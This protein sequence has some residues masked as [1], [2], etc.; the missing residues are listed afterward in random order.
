MDRLWFKHTEWL[1][2]AVA[3]LFFLGAYLYFDIPMVFSLF[4][5]L[6][7]FFCLFWIARSLMNREI[8]WEAG[9]MGPVEVSERIE[10]DLTNLH[11][12]RTIAGKIK[13]Q[14]A[15][16]EVFDI[17]NLSG[18]ILNYLRESR[19][20]L[21]ETGCFVLY[22][23]RLTPMVEKYVRQGND[24]AG[25]AGFSASEEAAFRR[26]LVKARPRLEKAL[27]KFKKSNKTK[28]KSFSHIL[29]QMM[30]VTNTKPQR[31]R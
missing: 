23:E 26:L 2:G 12:L 29:K 31:G 8:R 15:K 13:D 24:S 5:A 28:L 27:A 9:D 11:K 6:V 1:G 19:G 21:S 30:I 14:S 17:L 20:D 4:M 25:E 3:L 16:D 18:D 7:L 22:L 10:D